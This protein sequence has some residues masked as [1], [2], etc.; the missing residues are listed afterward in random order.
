MPVNRLSTALIGGCLIIVAVQYF[1]GTFEALPEVSLEPS[2]PELVPARPES[3]DVL[4][5][6]QDCVDRIAVSGAAGFDLPAGLPAGVSPALVAYESVCAP[7]LRDSDWVLFAG[8]YGVLAVA[9]VRHLVES[10]ILELS[11]PAFDAP[12]PVDGELLSMAAL[13]RAATSLR[14]FRAGLVDLYTLF[15]AVPLPV[16][17]DRAGRPEVSP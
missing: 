6:L 11:V 15:D 7:D 17:P 5:D 12:R 16:D 14:Q 8:D 13:G 2:L 9:A 4:R 1:S 10:E 3:R